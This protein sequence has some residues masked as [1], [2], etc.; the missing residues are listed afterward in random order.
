[1][2]KHRGGFFMVHIDCSKE[3]I[4]PRILEEWPGVH[5]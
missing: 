5:E 4:E 3:P 1:V 2:Q